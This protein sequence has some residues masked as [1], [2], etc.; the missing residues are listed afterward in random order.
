MEHTFL[1]SDHV[2][3]ARGCEDR[4]LLIR[5]RRFLIYDMGASMNSV[6]ARGG[7]EVGLVRNKCQESPEGNDHPLIKFS[8]R[9]DRFP[10]SEEDPDRPMFGDWIKEV[11]AGID[12]IIPAMQ[13]S[14]PGQ[15]NV[16]QSQ[17]QTKGDG[18]PVSI[19][20]FACQ[21]LIVKGLKEHFPS[22]RVIGEDP[23]HE[24]AAIPSQVKTLLPGDPDPLEICRDGLRSIGATDHRVWVIDPIDGFLIGG[25]NG[26]ATMPLRWRCSWIS[27]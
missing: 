12:I 11:L 9:N 5:I 27:R 10:D 17:V 23:S 7:D 16:Q 4:S 15:Q 22:D 3:Q 24:T 6:Y 18:T 19:A 25:H 1:D 21:T 20:D 14:L 13:L 8:V 26:R 2:V